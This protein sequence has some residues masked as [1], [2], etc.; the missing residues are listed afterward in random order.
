MKNPLKKIN[1]FIKDRLRKR[2]EKRLAVEKAK[3]EMWHAI[4]EY[5]LIRQGKSNLSA[6]KRKAVVKY[7]DDAIES[8]AIKSILK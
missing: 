4:H 6:S 8:G 2:A 3:N 7:I 1:N 5:G